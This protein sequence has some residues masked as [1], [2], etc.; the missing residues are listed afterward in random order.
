MKLIQ[1]A[2]QKGLPLKKA[3][4]ALGISDYRYYSWRNNPEGSDL[5]CSPDRKKPD[6]SVTNKQT[7]MALTAKDVEFIK[8]ELLKPENSTKS[9][10]QIYYSLLD[11][12][13][14]VGSLRSWQIYAKD[15]GLSNP[16]RREKSKSKPQ[17]VDVPEGARRKALVA[18]AKNKVWVWD[19]STFKMNNNNTDVYLF[20]VMDLYSRKL[21]NWRFYQSM[22]A[23]LAVEFFRESFEKASISAESGLFIHSDNGGPMRAKQTV[24]LFKE[25]GVGF[26]YSRPHH[27]N[28]NPHIES[29]FDTLKNFYGL[30]LYNCY[31]LE[32]ANLV[33]DDVAH[34]YNYEYYHSGIEYSLPGIRYD[35]PEDEAKLMEQRNK[36]YQDYKNK[37]PERFRFVD[38]VREFKVAGEQLLNPTE[39]MVNAAVKAN[40][41]C[42]SRNLSYMANMM[43][44][45]KG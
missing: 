44:K 27:S 3:C 2:T 20:A 21:I 45:R 12:S 39:E 36:T 26:T 34:K 13:I 22:H 7:A 42:L 6:N 32:A 35:S 17:K 16:N 14:V 40:S 43:A 4:K 28:D 33:L 30:K 11:D 9:I 37:H 29:L 41:G 1:E 8:E 19:I 23:D 31:S 15:L 24:D 5:R 25:Y 18:S 10:S 38:K